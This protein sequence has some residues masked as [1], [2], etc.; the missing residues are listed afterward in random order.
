MD[1]SSNFFRLYEAAED[2]LGEVKRSHEDGES[3]EELDPQPRKGSIL[4]FFDKLHIY[5][6]A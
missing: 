1:I 5:A 4:G 6:K 3:I 2:G